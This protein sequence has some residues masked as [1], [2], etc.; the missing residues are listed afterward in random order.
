[1]D[2]HRNFFKRKPIKAYNLHK[3]SLGLTAIEKMVSKSYRKRFK[4]FLVLRKIINVKSQATTE[5]MTQKLN[6]LAVVSE[7]MAKIYLCMYLNTIY[8][9]KSKLNVNSYIF[10]FSFLF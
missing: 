8:L 4:I 3:R 2:F 5:E 6:K 10:R 7:I 1:M 9:H